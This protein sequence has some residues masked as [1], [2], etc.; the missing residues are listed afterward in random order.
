[1]SQQEKLPTSESSGKRQGP[2]APASAAAPATP[3]TSATPARV[4]LDDA[5]LNGFHVKLTALT[6]GAHF[7]AGYTMGTI[8]LALASLAGQMYVSP[9]WQGL[10]ASSALIGVFLGSILTGMVADRMGRQKIFLYS[11]VLIAVASALQYFAS[12]LAG[13]F[14][15][16]VLVGFGIGADYSVGVTLLSEFLPRRARGPLCGCICTVWTV[17]YVVASVVGAYL[18]P[19]AD[20]QLLLAS[21]TVPAVIVLLMR[22]GTPE[23]PRW[24]LSQG[25]GDEARAIVER[26]V[27]PGVGIEDNEAVGG[28]LGML[29]ERR[30]LKTTLFV[31]LFWA[32]S[33]I[34]Y[35]GIYTFL[36]TILAA[37]GLA[38]DLAVDIVLNLV[39]IAGAV[40]GIMLI[41]RMRRRTLSIGSFAVCT[42]CLLALALVPGSQGGVLIGAF[43]LF[44]LTIAAESDLTAV[45]PPEVFPT[46]VRGSG[47]GLATGASRLGSAAGTFLLPIAMGA[48][49][50]SWTMGIM[51]AVCAAA[52]GVCI[53]WAP[54]T[55]DLALADAAGGAGEA[56]RGE[57]AAGEA[58]PAGE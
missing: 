34:P 11:F 46:E 22:V 4:M 17:G 56:P 16:R 9:L 48:L 18:V 1:M 5:P 19:S 38:E 13:L 54:E 42:A 57:R 29:F 43:A 37:L 12:G 20:W 27:G 7:T 53:A 47:I 10:I 44:T 55:K 50:L 30:Y 32:L 6:F 35:F 41:A 36:P 3:A 14:A 24:L 28:G 49:G 51:A 52:L 40:L 15:L 31:C 21:G 33:V 23:S 8:A 58:G 26:Y 25:R 2:A 45:Y 39:L